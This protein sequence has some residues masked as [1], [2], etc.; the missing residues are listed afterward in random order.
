MAFS[1]PLAT[2]KPL[3]LCDA[4]LY[5]LSHIVK[6]GIR[7]WFMHLFYDIMPILFYDILP[8]LFSDELPI[9]SIDTLIQMYQ[10]VNEIMILISE[11]AD[12][13]RFPE[14]QFL[15]ISKRLFPIYFPFQLPHFLVY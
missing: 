5:K 11:A 4:L 3:C 10:E 14:S 6:G 13:L 1:V 15:L 7:T 12:H 9:S 8:V 2:E